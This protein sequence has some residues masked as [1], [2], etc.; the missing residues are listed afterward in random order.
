M[1]TRESVNH[2][3]VSLTFSFTS[4][5]PRGRRC[6]SDLGRI[7]L[8]LGHISLELGRISLELAGISLELGRISLELDGVRAQRL[9]ALV[10]ATLTSSG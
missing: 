10:P 3:C 1:H 5:I 4:C 6:S 8:E 9:V 7:S 2:S